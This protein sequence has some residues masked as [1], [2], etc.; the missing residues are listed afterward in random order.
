MN[1]ISRDVLFAVDC[2]ACVAIVALVICAAI[3]AFGG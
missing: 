3:I 1:K 2:L